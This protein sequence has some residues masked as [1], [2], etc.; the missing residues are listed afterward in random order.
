MLIPIYDD[1]YSIFPTRLLCAEGNPHI[2]ATVTITSDSL[3]AEEIK[4]FLSNYYIIGFQAYLHFSEE[5]RKARA[6]NYGSIAILLTRF[7]KGSSDGVKVSKR[8]RESIY[9]RTFSHVFVQTPFL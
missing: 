5:R 4:V 3:G 6:L 9:V 7:V 8:K 1:L 2:E